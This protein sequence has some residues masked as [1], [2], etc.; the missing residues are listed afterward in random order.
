MKEQNVN[1]DYKSLFCM[2]GNFLFYGLYLK[3]SV[4][5]LKQGLTGGID[6]L[7]RKKEIPVGNVASLV[8]PVLD[9][10]VLL[11]TTNFIGSLLNFAMHPASSK[12]Q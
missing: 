8:A 10:I 11:S 4:R 6:M 7:K 1:L 2:G 12:S 3:N 5:I 9:D